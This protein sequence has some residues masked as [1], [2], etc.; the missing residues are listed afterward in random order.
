[1]V[2]SNFV[3]DIDEDKQVNPVEKFNENVENMVE[4]D[5]L[6]QRNLNGVTELQ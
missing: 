2:S 3:I 1:M 4:I 6:G 5:G